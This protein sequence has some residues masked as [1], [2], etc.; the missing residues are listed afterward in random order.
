MRVDYDVKSRDE[1]T[2]ADPGRFP[3]QIRGRGSLILYIKIKSL[4]KRKPRT[5]E[6]RDQVVVPIVVYQERAKRRKDIDQT[7]RVTKKLCIM[8]VCATALA[9][10]MYIA[11]GAA[12]TTLMYAPPYA[13]GMRQKDFKVSSLS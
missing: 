7:K 5:S 12:N 2:S 13:L 4:A 3:V 8:A 10:P 11:P 9:N 6:Y 1:Y